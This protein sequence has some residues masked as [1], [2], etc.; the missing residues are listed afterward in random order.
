MSFLGTKLYCMAGNHDDNSYEQSNPEAIFNN[1]ELAE[2]VFS[3]RHSNTTHTYNLFNYFFDSDK[4]EIRYLVLDT[5]KR[6]RDDQQI[7][8]IIQSISSVK[9]DW[10]IVVLSHIWGEWSPGEMTYKPNRQTEEI[11]QIFDAYNERQSIND[12]EFTCAKGK[13]V[14]LIGGHIHKDFFFHTNGGIPVLLLDSDSNIKSCNRLYPPVKGLPSEQCI[15]SILI[16]VQNNT[17]YAIRLGRGRDFC[18]EL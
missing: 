15:T 12:F 13:I 9:Q 17:G 1:T 4:E 8:F 5:S 10:S 14:L 6:Q 2:V 18:F 11:M 3:V 16:D 7:A